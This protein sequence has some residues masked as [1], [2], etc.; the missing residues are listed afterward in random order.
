MSHTNSTVRYDGYISLVD[1]DAEV[2][3]F[4]EARERAKGKGKGKCTQ[5]TADRSTRH[6]PAI[7]RDLS[8]DDDVRISHAHACLA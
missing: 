5:T 3:A 8:T 1:E 2:A 4:L 7:Q 6:V